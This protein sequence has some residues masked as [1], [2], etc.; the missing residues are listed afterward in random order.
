MNP[1]KPDR[2]TSRTRRCLKEALLA[3]I[4]E[5][6]YDA[7]KIEE[8]TE[9]ADLGRAT[10]Y[11]HYRDKE[12]LL[13]ESIDSLVDELL[14][15]VQSIPMDEWRLQPKWVLSG[16]AVETPVQL[17]FRHAA[18]NADLY[19]I[20][21]RGEGASKASQRLRE[22]IYNAVTGLLGLYIEKEDPQIRPAVPLEVF[23]NYFAV[24]LLGAIT[25]WLE[26][27]TPYSPAEMAR[28]FQQLFFLGGYQVLGIDSREAD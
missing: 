18:E 23:A 4:L 13:L 3:L 5:K 27:E 24:A 8:I 12:E 1:K 9:R 17:V 20:I 7:V 19:R 22:I 6:G 2:R 25:W 11:L 10:F 26:A 14:A 21:L 28:M 15:N 16:E